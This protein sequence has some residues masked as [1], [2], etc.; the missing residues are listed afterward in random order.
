[1]LF[2][3]IH[4]YVFSSAQCEIPETMQMI[5]TSFMYLQDIVAIIARYAVMENLYHQTSGA[6]SLSLKPEYQSSLLAL[7]TT[8]LQFFAT[9][10][11]L[12]RKL[13]QINIGG[14]HGEEDLMKT[15][16]ELV[17]DIKKIDHEC[18]GFRVVVDTV[19]EESGDSSDGD[20]EIEDVSDESWEV[21]NAGCIG[22]DVGVGVGLTS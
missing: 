3:Q 6:L 7:C 19:R 21:V 22:G 9:S 16:G 2:E 14:K 20:I 1:V 17:N 18:Q 8:V 13:S 10:F 5:K 12:G 15:C 4:E 11:E